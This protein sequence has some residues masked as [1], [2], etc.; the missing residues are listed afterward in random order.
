MSIFGGHL[1]DLF[2]GF[3]GRQL[4]SNLLRSIE[5][6]PNVLMHESQREIGSEVSLKDKRRFVIDNAEAN[7][8]G[9]DHRQQ[10]F[11]IH[12]QLGGQSKAFSEAFIDER[13]LQV[14]HQLGGL[15]LAGFADSEKHFSHGG[16]QGFQ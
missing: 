1:V 14:H 7:H 4:H 5:R 15:P 3:E 6:Q 12:S 11:D 9:L 13:N 2:D 16:K 8:G 10:F